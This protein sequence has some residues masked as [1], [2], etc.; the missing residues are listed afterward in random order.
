M[1]FKVINLN[2]IIKVKTEKTPLVANFMGRKHEL[3]TGEHSFVFPLRRIDQ[4]LEIDFS[5]F[6]PQE[7]SQIIEL[8]LF[9]NKKKLDTKKITS[10]LMKNNLYVE[11]KLMDVYDKVHFNGK[12]YFTFIRSWVEMEIISG[13]TVSKDKQDFISISEG[14]H[15][16]A[17]Q[18]NKRLRENKN[19]KHFI[20]MVGTCH[21][22]DVK[23]KYTPSLF[24]KLQEEYPNETLLNYSSE[25]LND[26]CILHNSLWVLDNLKVKNLLFTL[27][28]GTYMPHK[29]RIFDHISYWPFLNAP[30]PSDFKYEQ[31]LKL[32]RFNKNNMAM[33]KN[34]LNGKLQ[35]LLQRCKEEQVNPI[36]LNYG[37]RE[38]WHN[39]DLINWYSEYKN[40]HD[41]HLDKRTQI[42]NNKVFDKIQSMI[43]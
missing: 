35:L 34:I 29:I 11:N 8:E 10:F 30:S 38:I 41:V 17:E 40:N 4:I 6:T 5:G 2:L 1:Q 15:Q 32:Y 3:G 16:Q 23:K 14:N 20:A 37:S 19:K 43:V 28:V 18:F 21:Q 24:S 25:G 27:N 13:F 22:R 39:R 31:Q 33:W 36:I 12:L 26:W 9:Y 7:K 42:T